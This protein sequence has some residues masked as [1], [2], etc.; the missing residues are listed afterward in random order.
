MDY[1]FPINSFWNICALDIYLFICLFYFILF[2]YLFSEVGMDL[3]LLEAD[4]APSNVIYKLKHWIG[5]CSNVMD[6]NLIQVGPTW[7]SF[8]YA[9]L[10]VR[11][12]KNILFLL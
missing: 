7:A 3:T 8:F 4:W 1:G 5:C 11:S 10:I 2:I 12:S 6:K 9:W